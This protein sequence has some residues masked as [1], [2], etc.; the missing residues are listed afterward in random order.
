[1]VISGKGFFFISFSERAT[2]IATSLPEIYFS[3]YSQIFFRPSGF[4]AG[5]GIFYAQVNTAKYPS[6]GFACACYL[7]FFFPSI[8]ISC[9]GNFLAM[10]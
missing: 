8:L 6:V 3:I 9:F 10:V 1:M 2:K 4:D 7:W 5:H